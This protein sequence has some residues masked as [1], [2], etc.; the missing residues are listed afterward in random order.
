MAFI[1]K[2]STTAQNIIKI[3]ELMNTIVLYAPVL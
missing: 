1:E 2:N 3:T